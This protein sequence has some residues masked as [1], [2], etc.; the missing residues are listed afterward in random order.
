MLMVA[1]FLDLFII[2]ITDVFCLKTCP[3][4]VKEIIQYIFTLTRRFIACKAI[5]FQI[6]EDSLTYICNGCLG[7]IMNIKNYFNFK[8]LV[9][10]SGHGDHMCV[11][12]IRVMSKIGHYVIF[13]DK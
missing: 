6:N 5:R 13:V 7:L 8:G 12:V 11:E 4:C 1:V 10:G 3:S 2:N 9:D